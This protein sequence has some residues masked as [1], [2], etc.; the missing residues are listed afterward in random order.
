VRD[1]AALC[2]QQGRRLGDGYGFPI[3]TNL[4]TDIQ[5]QGLGH[6]HG[7]ALT[8]VLLESRQLGRQLVHSGRQLGE[9]VVAGFSADGFV[10]CAGFNI[11]GG[12]AHARNNRATHVG[13]GS[14]HCSAIAL[15]KNRQGE[16]EKTKRNS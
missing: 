10:S 2:P 13:D 8:H 9:C 7:D 11:D 15:G 4:H 6:E 12:D 5:S 3:R 16:K 14:G 1:F